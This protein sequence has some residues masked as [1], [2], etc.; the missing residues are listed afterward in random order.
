MWAGRSPSNDGAQAMSAVPAC[1][2]V[3]RTRPSCSPAMP[4][5]SMARPSCRSHGSTSSRTMSMNLHSEVD[6]PRGHTHEARDGAGKLLARGMLSLSPTGECPWVHGS[7]LMGARARLRGVSPK[8]GDWAASF[9]L[10]GSSFAG[11][12]VMLVPCV[13]EPSWIQFHDSWSRPWHS[14]TRVSSGPASGLVSPLRP[15]GVTRDG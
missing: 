3:L 2:N 4:L 8:H 13:H 1:P 11:V 5:R 10:T 7:M 14:W 15:W 9:I 12:R 6:E